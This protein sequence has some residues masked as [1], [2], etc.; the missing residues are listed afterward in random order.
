MPRLTDSD[1]I[2]RMLNLREEVRADEA[3]L[4]TKK[5]KLKEMEEFAIEL[6]LKKNLKSMGTPDGG[7]I[8]VNPEEVAQVNDWEEAFKYI[9][10]K[11]AFYLMF[12]RVNNAAWREELKARRNRDIPGISKFTKYKLSLRK[13]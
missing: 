1:R 12:K 6:L 11:N 9:R 13:G 5:A 2:A 3:V 7:S 8:A 4:K 10:K